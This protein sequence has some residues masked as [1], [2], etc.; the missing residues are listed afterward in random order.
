MSP[1]HPRSAALLVSLYVDEVGGA[2]WYAQ[3]RAFD[4]PTAPESPVERV[5]GEAQLIEAVRGWLAG[6]VARRESPPGVSPRGA[7]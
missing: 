2:G 7:S 6:V 4:D 1:P 3:L 5:S